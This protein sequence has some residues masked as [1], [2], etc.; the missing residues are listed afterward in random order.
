V[1]GMAISLSWRR[2]APILMMG[3]FC[4]QISSAANSDKPALTFHADADEV[5]LTFAAADQNDHG[6][7]TLRAADVVVI[8]RDIVVRK[9][10]SFARSDWTRL[11]LA[12][13]ADSSESVAPQFRQELA[14]ILEMISQ[15]DGVPEENLSVFGFRDSKPSL[16]CTG[17]CRRS[18]AAEQL[19]AARS[20][21]LTPLFDSIIFATDF[22][23][24]NNDPQTKKVL[25]IFSDGIDTVSCI[26]LADAIEAA[27]R[28]SVE[29]DALDLRGS[30]AEGTA[31]LNRLTSTTGGRYFPPQTDPLRVVNVILD[32]FRA[33]YEI[34]YRLPTRYPGFHAIRLMPS[35]K[36][37]L[38]FR[39]RSGYYYPNEIR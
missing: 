30:V 35:H 14:S 6:V 39:S 1:I 27:L 25:I 12:I 22:L 23:A 31:V 9:F 34:T 4:A 37:N 10:Q 13:L 16:I 38:Q 15:T 5:H 29:I 36:L 20:G 2:G 18:H 3:L 17:N 11:Q 32:G 21:E 24:Q 19:P 8:D 33:S 7:A 28:A 26:S